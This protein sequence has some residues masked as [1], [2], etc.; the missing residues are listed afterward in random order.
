MTL[1]ERESLDILMISSDV[2]KFHLR[3]ELYQ[4]IDYNYLTNSVKKHFDYFRTINYVPSLQIFGEHVLNSMVIQIAY[5]K[6]SVVLLTKLHSYIYNLDKWLLQLRIIIMFVNQ[7][8]HRIKLKMINQINPLFEKI[9]NRLEVKLMK[10]KMM[11][12]W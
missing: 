10:K 1:R 2:E 7:H 3:I 5:L 9:N 11:K 8:Q 6:Y 4:Q 12:R